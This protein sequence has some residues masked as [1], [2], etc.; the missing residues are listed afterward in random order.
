MNG[1]HVEML[2]DVFVA[3][4]EY[5]PTGHYEFQTECHP[6][7][8]L[9]L[10]F[11]FIQDGHEQYWVYAHD[12]S[13]P[14]CLHFLFALVLQVRERLRVA[15]ERVAT[16]EEDLT[17]TKEEVSWC[18]WS[19]WFISF[20]FLKQLAPIIKPVSRNLTK[21]YR[22]LSKNFE[23]WPSNVHNVCSYSVLEFFIEICRT[24]FI[25]HS[26]SKLATAITLLTCIHE[27]PA[28]NFGLDIGVDFCGLSQLLHIYSRIEPRIRP[29][30]LY[31]YLSMSLL[32]YH[33]TLST[34]IWNC[35]S[36]GFME[37]KAS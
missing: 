36:I 30:T 6:Y 29:Q 14:S 19:C 3:V 16:L 1:E 7:T 26:Q 31:P 27:V 22:G 15:L 33:S 18:C 23:K 37:N 4:W 17:S 9:E 10:H 8:S 35:I 11:V 25:T 2:R 21:L 12:F 32:T 5:Y 34:S 13:I 20:F 24:I 28:W